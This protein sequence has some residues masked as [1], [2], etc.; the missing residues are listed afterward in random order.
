MLFRTERSVLISSFLVFA[1]ALVAHAAASCVVTNSTT[2]TCT[3]AAGGSVSNPNGGQVSSSAYP[4][5][6]NIT[7]FNL[8]FSGVVSNASVTLR[9]VTADGS[10]GANIEAAGW[11]LSDAGGHYFEFLHGPGNDLNV[12]ESLSNATINISDSNSS[13]APNQSSYICPPSGNCVSGATYNWKSTSYTDPYPSVSRYPSPAPPNGNPASARTANSLGSGTFASALQGSAVNQV[14][15]L[16]MEDDNIEDSVSFSSWDLV[17][18]ISPLLST[19]TTVSSSV[20]PTFTT[21]SGNTTTFTATVTGSPTPTGTVTFT[22]TTTSTT[23]CSTVALSSGV[24]TCSTSFTTEGF[25]TV[26]ATYNPTSSYLGSNNTTNQ[27]VKNH[28]TL[29]SGAYC[30][31]GAI[32]IPGQQNSSP[33]PSIVNVGTD[34]TSVPNSLA[35]LTVMLN[36][37][38]AAA[39]NLE[40]ANFL[41][42]APDNTHSLEFLSYAGFVSSVSANVTFTDSASGYFPQDPSS[43]ITGTVSYLPTLYY[44]GADTFNTPLSPAPAP[45]SSF[46]VAGPGGTPAKTF[47]TEFDGATANGDWKLFVYDNENSPVSVTGGWCLKFTQSTGAATTTSVTGTPNGAT[48]GANVTVTATVLAGSTPVSSGTVTFTENGVQV[49]GGPSGPVSLNGSGQASFTT[50][51]LSEGDHTIVATFNGTGSDSLSFGSFTQRVDDATSLTISGNTFTY[52]N[53]GAITLPGPNNADDIGQASPNPSNIFVTAL[54]G[55]IN[56]VKVDL[57]S[58]HMQ[59]SDDNTASLLV[60]PT[61]TTAD[62]L[63]FFSNVGTGAGSVSGNFSLVDSAGSLVPSGLEPT[64]GTYKPTSYGS[65]A[66]SFFPSASGM[67]TLPAGPYP[68][69]ATEGTSTLNGVFAGGSGDGTW[70]L[71]FDQNTHQTSDG[72]TNGWCVD[73]TVTPPVLTVTETH[74]G[75]GTG[76]AFVAGKTGTYT[77]TVNNT[78]PGST[79]GQTVTLSDSLPSGL[80]QSNLTGS[81]WSCGSSTTTTVTCTSTSAVASGGSFPAIT[82]TITPALTSGTSASN[83]ATASGAGMTSG[84][85]TADVTTIIHEPVLSVGIVDN[86]SPAGTFKQGS[87]GDTATVTVSNASAGSGAGATS[88]TVTVTFTLS[89]ASAIVPASITPPGTGWTCQTPSASFTC[90]S[91][92]SPALAA[93]GS[94]VFTLNFSVS[95]GATSPQSIAASVSGGGG[96]SPSGTDTLTISSGPTLSISKSHSVT[97]TQGGTAVWNLQVT[98]SAPVGGLPTSG[99][100]TVVDPLPTG[101]TLSSFSGSGWSCSGTTTVTCTS[102]NAVAANGVNFP[103]LVL[104]VS[105]PAASPV[106]VSNLGYVYGGGD[107]VHIAFGSAASSNTDTVT[108]VQVPASMTAV[109]GTTPQSATISTAFAAAPAVTIRDANGVAVSGVSVTFAAPGTSPSGTFSN[110][111]NTITLTTNSSGIASAPFTANATAGGPYTVTANSSGLTTVNFSLSNTAG[112]PASMVANAGTTPQSATITTAFGTPLAVT[113]KDAG[114]NPLSGVSVTFTAPGTSPSGIFSNSTNTITATTNSSG[115]ASATFTAN[116]KAGGPYTVTAAASGLTTVNF[117]LTN[118]AGAPASM[119]ANAGTTP[120]SATVSTAFGTPLAVTIKDAGSNPLSGVSVTFT[121]PGTS[122]SG[123]FSNS[124]N[125]ITATTNSSG[126]ASAPF[127]ANATSGGPYT[128]TASSSG[129]ATVN[130]SLTNTA[131]TPP[132]GPSVV[133]FNV[134]FGSQSYNVIGSARTRLPWQITGISVVF[135]EVI[136]SANINSLSGVTTTG[137]SGL[138]T[139]TLTW[140]I[141]PVS[142]SNVSAVLAGSGP[143]A[144]TDSGSAGLGAGAGFTQALRVLWGDAN[145]DGGVNVQDQLIVNAARSQTYNILDDMNGDGVVNASDVL[146]VRAQT[147]T[148]NP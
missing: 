49:A 147:G 133:S 85:S 34:T 98:N 56:A 27:W 6:Y 144:I 122:P 104:T 140:T 105:V 68:R 53:V 86:G 23:L 19:T 128:V 141:S 92:G 127:T 59:G 50:S 8:T 90:S 145:D 28:S 63:D 100:T 13:Y 46:A 119:T 55:T 57:K 2:I 38:T 71:Y 89:S 115:I 94:A 110:S 77:I 9:G 12:T 26:Q 109:A 113:I 67:Y 88:S 148:T 32:S 3:G 130:F 103:L 64:A 22:D 120:Q 61:A 66:D 74:S 106:S 37:L 121:A 25:H 4:S 16:Y 54:P 95:A 143:N 114:S 123:T 78:G 139:N 21:S 73:L 96:N 5:S 18:T 1:S 75:P 129:L 107:P 134:L 44:N 41:L 146:V 60:G 11:L 80:T 137:F 14:W 51:S 52:C 35:T 45:P 111:T 136:T 87:T 138:G 69:A 117:L 112:A 97:F 84:T 65:S 126:I 10:Q 29:S 62:S 108:V 82:V 40:T 15:S 124:T 7:S 70:S 36:G 116:A 48:T 31:A 58:L 79:G 76:N 83:T 72:L 91:T 131:S 101:Y 30:N 99:T 142:L 20:N 81:G 102:T 33:Y 17:L 132:P 24:A 125:T 135:S 43:S 93:G 42:V 47:T 118:V 39:G